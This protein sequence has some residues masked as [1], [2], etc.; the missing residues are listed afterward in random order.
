[1]KSDRKY[2]EAIRCYIQ[3]LKLDKNNLQVLR[4]LS[5]LQMHTRD[6]DGCLETR[7]KLLTQRPNQ[8]ASWVG[9]AIV[10]HLRGNLDTAATVIYEF[11]KVQ[12]AVEPYNYEHSEL[13]MYYISILKE[14]S[15][16]EEALDFMD[17]HAKEIVD[18]VS[19]L[20]TYG[21]YSLISDF[22]IAGLLLQLGRV[23]DAETIVWQ[24]LERNPDCKSYYE[25]FYKVNEA[26]SKCA[27]KLSEK[28]QMLEE[29][30][31]KFPSARLPKLLFLETLDCITGFCNLFCGIGDE[32]GFHVDI[33]MRKYLRKGVPNLFVQLKRFYKSDE[34]RTTLENLYLTYRANL[35]DHE[36]LGPVPYGQ[37]KSPHLDDDAIE[38]PSTSLWLNYLI[39]QHYNYMRQTQVFT[40]YSHISPESIE[41]SFKGN[42]D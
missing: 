11:L 16:Y 13:L 28:R 32:F 19:Y 20:E 24:L 42:R 2:D 34:R 35:D 18:S 39:A 9:Y 23:D 40:A 14:S 41:C 5:V 31:E 37:S 6:L 30:V 10:Q 4:D 29:C 21:N 8:K 27:M 38:P 7:N 3:A 12:T 17:L 22:F 36:T 26:R 25:L 33:F 15:K 1:M